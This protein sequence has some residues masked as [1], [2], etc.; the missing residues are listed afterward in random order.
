MALSRFDFKA[1]ADRLLPAVLAAGRLEVEYFKSGTAVLRK[2]DASP[3]TIADQEAEAIIHSALAI[4]AP[5]IPVVAEEA[6]AAGQV[7][8]IGDTFFLVDPLD[9]TKS[10]IAGNPDFTVNIALIEHGRPTFGVVYAPATGRMFAA[11]GPHTAIEAIVRPDADVSGFDGIGAR[12]IFTRQP[13][14]KNLAAV[15]SRQGG[16][17]GPTGSL[18]AFDPLIDPVR[19]LLEAPTLGRAR[20]SASVVSLECIDDLIECEAQVLELADHAEAHH[21]VAGKQPVAGLGAIGARQ[22]SSPFVVA[23]S[24]DRHTRSA[25]QFPDPH[26]PETVRRIHR[27]W[28]IVQTLWSPL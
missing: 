11:L 8:E 27:L 1:L 4:A 13:D 18:E 2:S 17:D 19:H 3:V 28:S 7:P 25:R 26:V 14:M 15:A 22:H 23:H 16:S 24:V 20:R 21:G 12:Q 9:G 10:F 6:A 5:G